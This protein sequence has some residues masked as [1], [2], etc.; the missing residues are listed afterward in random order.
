MKKEKNIFLDPK[1]TVRLPG[2]V[3]L[4]T[5]FGHKTYGYLPDNKKTLSLAAT[6][7]VNARRRVVTP[8]R[9]LMEGASSTEIALLRKPMMLL[10]G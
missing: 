8:T 4:S 5:L 2:V 6:L 3:C 7:L 1:Q 10:A 9:E